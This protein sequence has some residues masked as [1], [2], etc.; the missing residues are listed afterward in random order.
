M[1]TARVAGTASAEQAPRPA[2]P[3]GR[4]PGETMNLTIL[5]GGGA[6]LAVVAF[7]LGYLVRARVGRNSLQSAEHR[8]QN[9]LE[10]AQREADT[11]RRNAVLEGR[12]EALRLKQQVERETQEV[13]NTQL[14]AERAFHE[15]EA[16]FSRRVELIEKKDRDL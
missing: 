7:L 6:A 11:S 9:V 2:P 10:Q 14:A 13:R 8:A 12:E 1:A 16:A 3:G 5:I 15:K 4:L